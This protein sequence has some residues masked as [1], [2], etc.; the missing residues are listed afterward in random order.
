MCCM[1]WEVCGGAGHSG[2]GE[3]HQ[4]SGDYARL[5][6]FS[7]PCHTSSASFRCEILSTYKG[8]VYVSC[9]L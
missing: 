4:A 1:C 7:L 6:L 2:E 8:E 5:H 3:Q 9:V